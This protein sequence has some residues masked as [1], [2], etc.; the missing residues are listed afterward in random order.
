MEVV[1]TECADTR[2]SVSE[3]AT[4]LELGE[5]GIWFSKGKSNI[6]YPSEGNAACFEIEDDSFWFQHRNR[7]ITSVVHGF[8]PAGTI[9]DLG[10]GNGFVALG[11]QQRGW[12]S[13]VVE[14][15]ITGA[16]NA[17][18]RGLEVICATFEDAHFRLHS[19]PAVGLFDVL[20]HIEDGGQFLR[21][22]GERLIVGGRIYLTVPAYR[23]LWSAE[24]VS[25]GHF[26]RYTL[27]SLARVLG[28]SGF[29]VEFASYI[30]SPLPVPIL[31]KRTIPTLLG[32]RKTENF[33]EAIREHRGGSSTVQSLAGSV[34]KWELQ[35]L[36]RKRT[37]PAGGSCLVVAKSV[38]GGAR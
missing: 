12:R 18:K 25:A 2:G 28:Q 35:R 19:L 6:S 11:L 21:M 24:D 20:E 30:F 9:F 5:H 4:N 26:R 38:A 17:R 8:P 10:G 13:I 36:E 23:W 31:L 1:E 29:D 33:D 22:L 14:P 27:S 15:G 32:R 7:C 37:I 3:I 34:F 16:V